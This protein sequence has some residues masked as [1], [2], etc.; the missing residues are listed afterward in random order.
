MSTTDANHPM[1][2]N[3]P[4][5]GDP[6]DVQ[7]RARP[8]CCQPAAAISPRRQPAGHVGVR[9]EQAMI[10]AN[11][12]GR[13]AG[14]AAAARAPGPRGAAAPGAPGPARRGRNGSAPE[15]RLPTLARAAHRRTAHLGRDGEGRR[16]SRP[17]LRVS[18][19]AGLMALVRSPHR[20]DEGA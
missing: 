12:Q 5:R 6:A 18:D 2:M 8:I 16:S 4:L 15:R 11:R 14:L 17:A 10:E 20:A 19:P 13:G 9:F 1:R 3:Q 7:A